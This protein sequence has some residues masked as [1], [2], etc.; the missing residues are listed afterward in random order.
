MRS[1]CNLILLSA[2]VMTAPSLAAKA[3]GDPSRGLSAPVLPY[4][5]KKT[6]LDNGLILLSVAFDSPGIIAYYTIVRAGSR[7]EVKK[8]LSGFAHFIEH[9]MFRGT[10]AFSAEKYNDV[11]KSLGAD[12]NASANE[13]VTTYHMTIPASAL[14]TAVQIESD[15]FQNL[16][17]DEPSFQKEARA[18]LGEYNKSAS[19]PF[20]KLTEVMQNQSSSGGAV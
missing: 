12:F 15:R 19:S 4:P 3:A 10:D 14:A 13:D 8:G 6:T 5:I 9:M 17:Y 7:N 18:V 16:K 1:M 2:I 11:L 20:Q